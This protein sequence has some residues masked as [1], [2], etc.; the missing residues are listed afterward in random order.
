MEEIKNAYCKGFEYAWTQGKI[1]HTINQERMVRER[2]QYDNELRLRLDEFI[3]EGKNYKN[4]N[5]LYIDP[6]LR[7]KYDWLRDQ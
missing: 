6:T 4:G 3:T 1:I 2:R 7:T 5:L